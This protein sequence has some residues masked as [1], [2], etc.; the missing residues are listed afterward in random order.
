[1]AVE[2]RETRLN[3]IIGYGGR[4]SELHR[5]AAGGCLKN[6]DRSFTQTFQCQQMTALLTLLT[7]RDTVLVEHAPVGCSGC[8][9][10][11][12]M[13][14]KAGQKLAK[15]DLPRNARWASTNLDE[16]DVI[17]GGEEKLKALILQMDRQHRPS[18]IFVLTSCASAIIGDDVHGIAGGLQDQVRARIVPIACEGFKSKVSATGYDVCYDAVL[19]HLLE[20]PAARDPD[21]LN[22]ISP[23]TVNVKDQR[24]IRR[25][26]ARLGI[27]ANFAPGFSDAASLKKITEAAA[28]I[29]L[30]YVHADY[31]LEQLKR[32]YGIPYSR[33]LMPLG[34][35]ATDRWL[36]G[37]ADLF[38]RAAAARDLIQEEHE[39]IRPRLEAIRKVLKGKT[40]FISLGSARG[41]AVGALVHELGLELLGTHV[42]HFDATLSEALEGDLEKHGDFEINVANMQ[43]FEQAS[44]LAKIKPDLFI[45]GSL[46]ALRQGI[47]AVQ[48]IDFGRNSFGYDGI[49]EVGEKLL[50]AVNNPGFALGLSKHTRL[51]Y[52][53]DWLSQDPYKYLK[54][55]G[56]AHE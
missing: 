33:Q 6:A 56:P 11:V 37:A 34:I 49:L 23:L 50:D 54:M 44:L 19:D 43:P 55:D 28:S 22:V 16:N 1:M 25:L 3:S 46:W 35:E 51:P 15:V 12:N 2:N 21:L 52:K 5:R 30:C 13:V 48:I 7:I 29:S 32:R 39:R 17:H 10:F 8:A 36:L 41:V 45:G 27:Q 9:G 4:A 42:F 40:T 47:N 14:Y 18:V 20:P 31:F 53:G 38:G 26:L 24:E